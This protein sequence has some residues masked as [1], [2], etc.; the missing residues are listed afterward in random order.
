MW[1]AT[2]SRF[3]GLLLSLG[4]RDHIRCQLGQDL[5]GVLAESR[6]RPMEHSWRT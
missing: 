6:R 4:L 5:R 2:R 1:H 3:D